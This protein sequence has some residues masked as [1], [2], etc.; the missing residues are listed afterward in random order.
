MRH[1][2]RKP[3]MNLFESAPKPDPAATRRLKD[4]TSELLALDEDVAVTVNGLRRNSSPSRSLFG[5][6]GRCF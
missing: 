4:W 6:F 1:Q 3:A 5:R 2:Q